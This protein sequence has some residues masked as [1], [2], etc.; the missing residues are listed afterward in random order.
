MTQSRHVLFGCLA[1][2]VVLLSVSVVLSQ[3]PANSQSQSSS[4]PAQPDQQ[5]SQSS[6]QPNSST[7]PADSNSTST[8]STTSSS[9][10][11]KPETT[12]SPASTGPTTSTPPA[13][14]TVVP[15]QTRERKVGDPGEKHAEDAFNHDDHS[16]PFGPDV[17]R[18]FPLSA[19]VSTPQDPNAYKL[20]SNV[21]L[22][23]LDVSVKD[24]SGGF[25]SGLAKDQFKIFDNGKPVDIRYFES[26][27][28]PVS[29]G[30][31]VDSSGSMR[32]KRSDVVTAALAFVTASNPN[33]QLFVVGF[34]DRPRMGLP[35]DMPFTDDRGKLR[36]ALLRIPAEGRTAMND[37]LQTGLEH[38]KKGKYYKKALVLI[39][40]G[41][42]NA[43]ELHNEELYRLIQ[44]SQ[45]TI[46][47][48]GIYDDDDKDK[49]PGVLKRIAALTGGEVFLPEK[50]SDLVGVCTRIAKDI[51]NRYSLGFVPPSDI[52]YD[53]KPRILKIMAAAPD[54]GKLVV[55]ARTSY[56][57]IGS[58]P[59]QPATLAAKP[60]RRNR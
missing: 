39:S 43:S 6:A 60:S 40:D 30:L 34:N 37:A 13:A 48:I 42:D 11:D 25:V 51:R 57:A 36:D 9:T 28:I 45:A 16:I 33:D 15:E 53:G 12:N 2:L 1:A 4:T 23:L 19:H 20:S 31:V 5:Q 21:D 56:I 18:R 52:T 7:A 54:R 44:E 14:G 58:Q 26:G 29:L 22:V 55:R 8:N 17:Q 32:A 41:G 38:L 24:T 49:N 59:P 10:S 27:D 47:T 46:Y 50:L 3:T 35:A